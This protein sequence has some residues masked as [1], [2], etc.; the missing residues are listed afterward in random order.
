MSIAQGVKKLLY[1][2][3]GVSLFISLLMWLLVSN[4]AAKSALLAGVVCVI[5]NG[6]FAWKLFSHRGARSA[7]K[8]VNSFYQGEALK[9]LV[10]ALLF[11][12]VFMFADVQ[13]L[14]FFLS[15]IVVQM[16]IWFAPL[17]INNQQD[18]PESD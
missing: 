9:L 3:V 4:I 15:F 13:P 10:A 18:G 17:L 5:P 8:I 16:S 6:L 1:L 12:L 2:Q 11:V 14:V 7:K